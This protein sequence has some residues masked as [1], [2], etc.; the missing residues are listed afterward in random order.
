MHSHAHTYTTHMHTHTQH[1]CTHIY[2]QHICTHI[3]NTYAHTYTTHMH[4]HTQH[5]CTH[6]H[7]SNAQAQY[8]Y[9][10]LLSVACSI[11]IYA[12]VNIVP[13]SRKWN[14]V[15]NLKR[16]LHAW[17]MNVCFMWA[18]VLACLCA[19]VRVRV[20]EKSN[21]THSICTCLICLI[22]RSIHI[23]F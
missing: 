14:Q 5:I 1:I 12:A 18:R 10:V 17:R 15:N 9:E 4:T 19:R 8:L 22:V 23:V 6:I 20:N 13:V 7:T 11:A 2:T 16:L 3:H 21:K